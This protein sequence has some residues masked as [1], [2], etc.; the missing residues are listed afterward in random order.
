ALLA[1]DG[2][3]VAEGDAPVVTAAR[4]AGGAAVLLPAVE[5]VGKPVVR[6]DVLYL[7]GRL[8]VL[9][10][11]RLS[12]VDRHDRALVGRGHHVLGMLRVDPQEVEVVA[13]R[14]A[15]EE[16]ERLAGVVRASD[17]LPGHVDRVALPRVHGD[18][19]HVARREPRGGIGA[20]P[21]SAAVVGAV[22]P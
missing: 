17:R 13:A 7:P 1:A 5:P 14:R 4:R 2:L 21:R 10:A 8:V 20:S 18:A 11:P 19:I 9:V 22:E 6:F 3:P 12:A 15:A 16:R